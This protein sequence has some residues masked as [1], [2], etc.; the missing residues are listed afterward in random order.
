[1]VVGWRLLLIEAT[2]VGESNEAGRAR[3]DPIEVAAPS[4][5]G[6]ALTDAPP[7]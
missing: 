3:D 2:P 6:E 7:P 5:A 1:V 4:A